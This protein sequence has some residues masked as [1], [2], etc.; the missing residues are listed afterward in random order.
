MKRDKGSSVVM[1]KGIKLFT[2]AWCHLKD[3]LAWV[4]EEG[5]VVDKEGNACRQY[6]VLGLTM[7][8]LDRV[9]IG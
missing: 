9:I 4:D 3:F 2:I 1:D 5:L 7:W 6:L 8:F